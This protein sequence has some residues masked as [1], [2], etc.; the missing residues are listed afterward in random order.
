MNDWL[1][2]IYSLLL[3][4]KSRFTSRT[5]IYNDFGHNV[6]IKSNYLSGRDR[7]RENE[8]KTETITSWTSYI[9]NYV[10]TYHR[11]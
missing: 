1:A 9:K 8:K 11:R 3:D 7:K 6:E 5:S 2:C 10:N 4:W